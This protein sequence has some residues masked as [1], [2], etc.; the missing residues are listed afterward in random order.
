MKWGQGAKC[1]G[2]EIKV[3]SLER[4]LKFKKRGYIVTP[5]PTPRSQEAF[6]AGS[7]KEFESHSRLG[8]V[9]E[10]GFM[11]EVKRLGDRI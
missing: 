2:G 1:I 5:D 9:S 4:A 6:K 10:E 8:F 11:E 3:K 7:I